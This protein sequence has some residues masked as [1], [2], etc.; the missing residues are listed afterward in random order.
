MVVCSKKYGPGKLLAV[1]EDSLGQMVAFTA[2]Q[3]TT[4]TGCTMPALY[5]EALDN[6]AFRTDRFTNDPFNGSQAELA[7]DVTIPMPN[8]LPASGPIADLF[9]AAGINDNGRLEVGPLCRRSLQIARQDRD[10]WLVEILNGCLISQM[11]FNFSVTE[12][13]SITFSGVARSKCEFTGFSPAAGLEMEVSATTNIDFATL[14][15]SIYRDS[16]NLVSSDL[17]ITTASNMG[18]NVVFLK[19]NGADKVEG[20]ISGWD[21]EGFSA[22]CI[23]AP[24]D[25]KADALR[26]ALPGVPVQSNTCSTS[27]WGSYFKDAGGATPVE[28]I[29][30]PFQSTTLTIETG[31]S[32]GELTN[33]DAALPSE[34]I[35]AQCKV[36][37][38]TSAYIDEQFEHFMHDDRQITLYLDRGKQHYI[39]CAYC[40][41]TERPSYDLSVD[42]AASGEISFSC[43]GN[44]PLLIV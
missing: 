35:S 11:V 41:F 37:G 18:L 16:Y 4:A 22:A 7:F 1:R 43:Y 23:D 31:V 20:V 44:N 40:N 5:R 17:S 19:N 14:G 3:A 39:Q 29:A 6:T 34:V 42:N 38:Q 36:T 27:D 8:R 2:E 15:R 9:W 13:P 24:A 26:F 32:F 12:Q 21:H 33:F 10:G 30:V 25:F 28:E